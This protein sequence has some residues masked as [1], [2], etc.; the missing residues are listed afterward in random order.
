VCVCVWETVSEKVNVTIIESV[1]VGETE[2]RG[3][4]KRSHK[5]HLLKGTGILFDFLCFS[6]LIKSKILATR[7]K[8]YFRLLA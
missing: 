2:R 6:S 5:A 3:R 8:I 1:L 4:V 7:M